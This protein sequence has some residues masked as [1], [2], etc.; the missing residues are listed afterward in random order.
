MQADDNSAEVARRLALN[1]REAM[2]SLSL[3]A[4]AELTEVDHSTIQGLLTGRAWPDLET[5]ARLEKGFG[6]SL[7]PGLIED[8]GS[9]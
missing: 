7:W 3:R 2:G 9:T 5:I 6:V 8:S 1:V 4:A